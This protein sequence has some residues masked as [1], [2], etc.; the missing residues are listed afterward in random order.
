M[1]WFSIEIAMAT[2]RVYFPRAIAWNFKN[3][4]WN[5]AELHVLLV[6]IRNVL[7][8]NKINWTILKFIKMKKRRSQDLNVFTEK[9]KWMVQ[10]NHAK[11]VE[12]TAR[13]FY[14]NSNDDLGVYISL[15]L[16]HGTSKIEFKI[17]VNFMCY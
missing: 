9:A 11:K 2:W 6:W 14:R 8:Y 4:T 17:L 3:W 16:Q 7:A 10:N 13:M 5:L 15:R 1:L 12:H